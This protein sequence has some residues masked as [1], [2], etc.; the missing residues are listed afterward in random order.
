[1]AGRS[2]FDVFDAPGSG[3]VS[4]VRNRAY[5]G[6][7]RHD[8]GREGD[9]GY[10]VR[11]IRTPRYLYC[12]NFEPDRWPAG[13]PETNYTNCD[14]S[15]TKNRIIELKESGENDYY[16]RLAFGKRP[17]EELYDVSSDPHC[18]ENLAADDE[19]ARLREELWAELRDLLRETGDPRMCG[20]PE[21]FDTIEYFADAPHSWAHYLA[22]DW[23]PPNY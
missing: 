4:E 9:L 8:M 22:G 17:A 21:Y 2:L 13:N 18:I 16:W 23:K 14:S 15:P 1:M 10:P 11:C 19:F 3:V 5:M 12:R 7:E 6:R 20:A